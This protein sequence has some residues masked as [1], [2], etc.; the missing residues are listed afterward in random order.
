MMNT[1]AVPGK[2]IQGKDAINDMYKHIR[3]LG[4]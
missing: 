2:Y 4:T 3:F 1:L